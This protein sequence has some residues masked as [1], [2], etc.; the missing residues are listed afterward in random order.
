MKD[1]D[2][3]LLLIFIILIIYFIIDSN[4]KYN[5]NK[6]LKDKLSEYFNNL[7]DRDK[8]KYLL[9]NK[10]HNEIRNL[11]PNLNNI[12]F[13]SGI[14]WINLDRSHKR[15]DYMINI[16]KDINIPNYRINAIDGKV[17]EDIKAVYEDIP[18]ERE[19]SKSE[20]A[21]TLSHIKAI[22][23]LKNIPGEYFMICEDDISFDN[24]ILFEYDLKTII[25]ECPKFD[26]LLLN[27]TFLNPIDEKYS[28]WNDYYYNKKMQIGSAVCY[29]ISRSGIDKIIENAKYID[30]NNF[31]LNK[32]HNFD[33]SDIYIYKNL[34]TYVYKY[35][36]ITTLFEEST[37]HNNHLNYH[38]DNDN[39]Q[40]GIILKDFYNYDL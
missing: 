5:L 28:N 12:N 29:I 25:L 1:T 2:F 26:I 8:I 13:I 36:Y 6:K 24:I 16:L 23:Y 37:I 32:N 31:K 22:N 34:E 14:A 38:K 35:N 21:C 18:A 20:I 33:V 3:I 4:N 10:N 30:D 19:L 9:D 7:N 39:F 15:R 40:L 17:Y 27:K 11:K